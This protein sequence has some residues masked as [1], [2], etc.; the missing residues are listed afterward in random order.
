[1]S[2]ELHRGEMAPAF[3]GLGYAQSET[4]R[5]ARLEQAAYWWNRHREERSD[6]AI[7][8]DVER[9]TTPGL[10]RFARNDDRGSTLMQ[11]A[12]P[13]RRSRLRGASASD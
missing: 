12:L 7:Q 8:G 6:V 11:F 9:S 10:L 4:S 2:C 1:M 13:G 5:R 3:A